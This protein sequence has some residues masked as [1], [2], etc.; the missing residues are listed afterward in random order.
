[1]E[2]TT[3]VDLF[4]S[5]MNKQLDCYVSLRPDP[6]AFAVDAF[7]FPRRGFEFYAFSPF[8]LIPKVLQ[9]GQQDN[10]SGVLIVPLWRAQVWWP[11]LKKDGEDRASHARRSRHL[12]TAQSSGEKK[13][14]KKQH[15]LLHLQLKAWR[16]L[17]SVTGAED[18]PAKQLPSS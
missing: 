17:E 15:L 11:V 12:D 5:R 2:I 4:A 7:S 10:S 3:S 13:K 18:I 1:M 14:K 8:S 9:K 16:I 6:E